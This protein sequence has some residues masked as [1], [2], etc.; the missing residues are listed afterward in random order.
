MEHQLSAD[1]RPENEFRFRNLLEMD[2]FS[3]EFARAVTMKLVR[4]Y[5]DQ[6]R[7]EELDQFLEELNSDY[8]AE[9]ER[10]ECIGY[11]VRR[12]LYDKAVN[13]IYKYGPEG[14]EES[15]I[16]DLIN[17]W[18][19][20]HR[21]DTEQYR[22]LV[23]QLL[24]ETLGSNR[25]NMVNVQYLINNAVGTS[26]ILRDIWRKAS[27]IGV[28]HRDL[29]EKMII[30]LLY[31]G[32]YLSEKGGIIENYAYNLP[33]GDVLRAALNSSSY[34]YFVD[35]VMI[36]DKIFGVL[37]DAFETELD[38]DRV[39][40]LAYVKFYAENKDRIDDKVKPVL[41][42]ALHR[43]MA[44]GVV[45]ACFRELSDIMPSMT[46]YADM[47][48]VE[49]RTQSDSQVS[50]HYVIESDREDEYHSEQMQEVYKG[51]YSSA[52]TLFFGEKLMYYITEG[53]ENENDALSES[54]SIM[55]SDIGD[56]ISKGRFGLVNDICIGKTLRD[57]ATVDELLLEFFSKEYMSE[58]LFG[59]HKG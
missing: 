10:A 40:D 42:D 22:D 33:D 9:Y 29:E 13:W 19:P 2:Y 28:E 5:S 18:L 38:L 17:G 35:D 20:V 7:F 14:I 6:E 34:E 53:S 27:E 3:L 25:S 12:S 48:I 31:S 36:S 23:Q 57:Y 52:F 51:V 21:N 24:L 26:K 46:S 39:C 59:M 4:F 30:Q 37:T 11:L 54:N 45:M 15:V 47:T 1:I 49:Y 58:K 55:R 16:C 41:K 50:I 44:N 32:A 56:S 43:L 8:V